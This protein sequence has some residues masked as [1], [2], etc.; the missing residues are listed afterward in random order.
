M[1][2]RVQRERKGKGKFRN[3]SLKREFCD[4][5]EEWIKQNPQYAYRSIAQFCEDASRIRLESLG[6]YKKPVAD[7][8]EGVD[9]GC[10]FIVDFDGKILE[11]TP[12]CSA[13]T[14]RHV[15]DVILTNMQ[16]DPT[17][18]LLELVRSGMARLFNV[19]LTGVI[20]NVTVKRIE[21]FGRPAIKMWLR[22]V[23][24]PIAGEMK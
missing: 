7:I 15:G 3:L 2:K 20:V 19:K 17:L 6:A 8:P 22:P 1:G 16:P 13:L 9:D 21:Y 23:E 11:M 4:T 14:H 10:R 5:I 12:E 24:H 18:L